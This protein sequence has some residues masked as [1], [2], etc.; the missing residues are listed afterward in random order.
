VAIAALLPF[1][2]TLGSAPVLDD[3]WAVLDN[4]L[5]QGGLRNAG[6][7]LVSP[8]GY[9]G[10]ATQA[11]PFRPL[12]T[13]SFAASYALHG[14]AP[15]GYH[16]VNLGLHAFAALLVLALA[17]RLADRVAPEQA[18]HVALLAGMLFAVHPAHVEAIAPIVGRSELLAACGALGALLLALGPPRPLRL[19]GAT[20]LLAGAVLAKEGAVVT[21]L[22]YA[23]VSAAVPAAAGLEAR[24]GPSTP[25]GRRA[26]GRLALVAGTLALAALPY[27]ALR[28]F[29]VAAPPAARWFSGVPAATVALSASRVLAEYLRLLAFPLF[30]GTDF[31]YA[32][33][34]PRIAAPDAAFAAGTATWVLTLALAARLWRR[35]PLPSAGLLWTFAALLPV[36]HLV[37]IG[38]LMAERLAYLPSAGFCI[39]AGAALAAL[40]PARP[41]PA[42]APPASIEAPGLR[43]GTLAVLPLAAVA[44]L[45]ARAAARSLDWHDGL[46]LWKAELPKAPRDPVVNNNLAAA[47]SARGEHARALP[48][49]ETALASAPGYW[50]AHVNLGIARQALGDRAGARLAYAQAIRIAPGASS[51]VLFL[52]RLHA[53]EGDLAGAVALL[54]QARRI[55]PEE[56]QLA[57]IQ[58]EYLA[59]LGRTVE[60]RQAY[61]AALALDPRDAEARRALDALQG[62]R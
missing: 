9:A 4:P 57:R 24:P 17:R 45:A 46:S 37:P 54:S 32:A 49:L 27:L 22:L 20:A 59:R 56:A 47:Y 5:V 23:I 29:S 15:L 55:S 60:A 6:R 31:A 2:Y 34:I 44:L 13:L 1:L 11:G 58:G 18:P 36:L 19:L 25:A 52:A 21:P 40:L 48:L 7:I 38:V 8:Y 30:L 16:A 50:R 42:A 43:R 53:E 14:R 61:G 10:G 39:A 62:A 28:G 51:P 33:R 35:A 41:A 3:G 12:T 26:L